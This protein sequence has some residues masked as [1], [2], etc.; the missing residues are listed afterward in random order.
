MSFTA[1]HSHAMHGS[2]TPSCALDTL[3]SSLLP[4]LPLPTSPL[5][6]HAAPVFFPSSMS[7]ASVDSYLCSAPP[8][9]PYTSQQS[10]VYF[11]NPSPPPLSVSAF[12]GSWQPAAPLFYPHTPAQQSIRSEW[13]SRQFEYGSSGG[14]GG[15]G[16]VRAFGGGLPSLPYSGYPAFEH[17]SAGRQRSSGRGGRQMSAGRQRWDSSSR[18]RAQ[19]QS[20]QQQLPQHSPAQPQQPPQQPHGI[21][22]PAAHSP[23]T[24][25][26]TSSLETSEEGSAAARLESTTASPALSSVGRLLDVP[27]SSSRLAERG[28]MRPEAIDTGPD[29]RRERKVAATQHHS[30]AT[31]RKPRHPVAHTAPLLLLRC[32][33]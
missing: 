10:T 20:T 12:D 1:A 31:V 15:M 22:L 27:P 28:L 18:W 5:N 9:L 17:R 21:P 24:T 29:E 33:L 26:S 19:P 23:S 8:L 32:V 30:D 3:S 16:G 11:P 25:D 13:D 2:A 14:G 4:A 7:A 6:P